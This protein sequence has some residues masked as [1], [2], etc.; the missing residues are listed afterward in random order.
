MMT[1]TLAGSVLRILLLLLLK[2]GVIST[3]AKMGPEPLEPV[4]LTTLLARMAL[5]Q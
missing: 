2:T 5:L 1:V 4:R 3:I